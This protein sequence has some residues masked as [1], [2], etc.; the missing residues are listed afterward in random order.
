MN[1]CPRCASPLAEHH[2]DGRDRLVC[3]A[4]C[5]FVHWNNP[6]PVAAALVK[7]GERYVI[8]R[9]AAWPAHW[10]SL[11]SGFLEAGES[12]EAAIVR[13]TR[14]ELG[15]EVDR[16][17]FIA[18]H[19]FVPM[20]Q[21]MICYVVEARGELVLDAELAEVMTLSEDEL[22]R[23]DFGEL[24]LPMAVTRRWFAMQDGAAHP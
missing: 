3:G 17:H 19:P 12:P 21:L 15:L 2:H 13:E 22:R 18:H 16:V 6:T 11:I 20:N 24:K 4:A 8:A 23:H 5:G 1:Y 10:F 14:E 7:L 9:N